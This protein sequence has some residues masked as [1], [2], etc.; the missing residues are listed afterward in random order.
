M[1]TENPTRHLTWRLRKSVVLFIFRKD[2]QSLRLRIC[3]LGTQ[4]SESYCY[5]KIIG[6][7]VDQGTSRYWGLCLP[8]LYGHSILTPELRAVDS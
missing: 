1:A 2:Y 6:C 8:S 7:I 5:A 4:T 3:L